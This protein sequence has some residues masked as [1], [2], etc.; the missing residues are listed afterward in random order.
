MDVLNICL[1]NSLKLGIIE[2]KIVGDVWN[3]IL[4]F[5]DPNCGGLNEKSTLLMLLCIIHDLEV[6]NESSCR[7]WPED[8]KCQLANILENEASSLKHGGICDAQMHLLPIHFIESN[9]LRWNFQISTKSYQLMQ[10]FS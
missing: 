5:I 8:T 2:W 7:C 10:W 9:K 4:F 3:S 6:V 1:F